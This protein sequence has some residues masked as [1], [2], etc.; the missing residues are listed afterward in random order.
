[1][2]KLLLKYSLFVAIVWTLIIFVLCCTPG[3]YI[4]TTDWLELLSFDK[5]VHASIFFTLA[6]LWLVYLFKLNKLSS[7]LIVLVILLCIAY[8]GLL[9]IMQATVFS[10]RSGDWLDFIAN[11]FG[12]L[13]GL[14]FFSK[15]N[16]R[17]NGVF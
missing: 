12:C 4:P 16:Y 2:I 3:Q 10:H 15:N 13:M 11:T 1:M 5:F 14:W 17:F 7:T 9:E 6:V 8:G